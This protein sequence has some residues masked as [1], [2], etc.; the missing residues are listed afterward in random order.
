MVAEEDPG[1]PSYSYGHMENVMAALIETNRVLMSRIVALK[2]KWL[3]R[4]RYPAEEII[5]D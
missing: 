2:S 5:F 3:R 4:S 1:G